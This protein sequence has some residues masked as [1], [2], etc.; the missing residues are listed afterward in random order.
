ML[1]HL[2]RPAARRGVGEHVE[3]SSA[4]ALGLGR[5]DDR[6]GTQHAH[7]FRPQVVIVALGKAHHRHAGRERFMDGVRATVR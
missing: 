7:A 3:H 2:V 1:R 5:G 6:T 4:D